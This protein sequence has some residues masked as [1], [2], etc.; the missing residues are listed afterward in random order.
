MRFPPGLSESVTRRRDFLHSVCSG[1]SLSVR[2]S[3]RPSGGKR[4]WDSVQEADLR[5]PDSSDQPLRQP[6]N[7]TADLVILLP[8]LLPS[9]SITVMA[10][11]S[12]LSMGSG[13]FLCVTVAVTTASSCSR[14][15]CLFFEST[16][17]A[18]KHGKQEVQLPGRET[19][20]FACVNAAL[21]TVLLSI[22]GT[23]VR[24]S[25]VVWNIS[26]VELTLNNNF[27]SS[28]VISVDI[29]LKKKMRGFQRWR[30]RLCL[31]GERCSSPEP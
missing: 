7:D 10:A 19:K 13:I 9:P 5:L 22:T 20:S 29:L 21:H 4:C 16:C 28:H 17:A 25:Y 23:Y 15:L 31:A 11:R 8:P 30:A 3:V 12:F 18:C 24:F 26:S 2:A 6:S 27:I 1:S 14:S